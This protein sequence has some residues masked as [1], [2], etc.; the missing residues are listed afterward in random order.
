MMRYYWQ[1]SKTIKSTYSVSDWVCS[2]KWYWWTLPCTKHH[3]ACFLLGHC[4]TS[5][6]TVF[7]SWYL[8]NGD[9]E[10]AKSHQSFIF[11]PGKI[12]FFS[13]LKQQ[14]YSTEENPQK[15]EG[16]IWGLQG[17]LN[18]D[19]YTILLFLFAGPLLTHFLRK[20]SSKSLPFPSCSQF[21]YYKLLHLSRKI[22]H[23]AFKQLFQ[24]R[25][26]GVLR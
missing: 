23:N 20:D 18:L 17:K 1:Q 15:K 7:P 11:P 2:Q 9:S 26:S 25:F 6:I 10:K 8:H 4:P 22:N 14:S 3:S 12:T 13:L 19:W 21:F 24:R 5:W 16:N